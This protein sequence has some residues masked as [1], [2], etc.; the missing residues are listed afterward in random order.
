MSEEPEIDIEAV[1]VQRT[2]EA[3]FLKNKRNLIL[4]ETDKYLLADFPITP[5][6]LIIVKEYRQLLRN[7]TLNDYI[8]P[9][10]PSFVITM[11]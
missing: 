7:F 8:L 5:E 3:E 1:S 10:K 2:S 6:E 11:N 4:A 9:E